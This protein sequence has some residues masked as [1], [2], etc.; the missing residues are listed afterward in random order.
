[1]V[2]TR[3]WRTVTKDMQICCITAWLGRFFLSVFR[4]AIF[5]K[6]FYHRGKS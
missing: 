5:L 3:A 2:G 1:M 6:T 4:Y